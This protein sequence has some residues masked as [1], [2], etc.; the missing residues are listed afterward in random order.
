MAGDI[1]KVKDL[2]GLVEY[3]SAKLGWDIDFEDFDDIGDITY[4]FDASDIGLKEEAFAKISALRQLPPL[5]DGQRWGIFSVEFDSKRFEVTALRKILSGLIP[6]RRN[7]ADHAVWDQ[8]DLL[9]LCFWGEGNERTVGV[10]HFAEKESGLPQIRM[11]YCAP[12][13]EDFTQINVFERRLAQLEW[14]KDPSDTERWQN[15]WSTAFK[16]AYRQIITD[17][18]TLTIQLACEAQNIRNLILA[19]LE[20][21]AANGYVHTL[22]DRFKSTLIHDMTEQQFADM[23][24]QTVVYGLFSARC[25]DT[26]QEDFSAAEAVEC[27]PNTNPFLKHLMKECLGAQENSRLSFDELGIGDVVDLLRYTRTD[28][29]IQDFNRQTGGGREDPV[30]HFYEEFL[31]AYDKAQKVQ[32]GV[33]YTP[34]PVVNFI[35]RAVDE[36]L[37]NEFGIAD[38]LAST[39]TKKIHI[40]RDSRRKLDGFYRKVEDTADVP[41]VQVLDP[42]TGTGTFLRQVILQIYSNYKEM[43]KAGKETEDG[44]DAYVEEQLLPRINGFELMMAPYAVAHMKLAMVLRDTGYD[45]SSDSRLNVYLTNTLEKPGTSESQ[46]AFWDD[47]L[48]TESVEANGVKKNMGINV[49]IGNPPYLSASNSKSEFISGLMQDYKIEP[50]GQIKLQERKNWLD[51]DYVKFLRFSENIIEKSGAGVVGFINPHGWLENGGFR[52]M[53]W[54]LLTSFDEIYILNLHGN[55]KKQ[56]TCPDGSKDENVFDI[57]QGVCINLLVKTKTNPDR[58]KIAK[59]YYAD[60]YGLRDQKYSFLSTHTIANID[61]AEIHPDEP[62]FYLIPRDFSGIEAYRTGFAIN[63]VFIVSSQ[64]VMSGN[65]VCVMFESR[66]DAQETIE[67]AIHA[68]TMDKAVHVIC[69][70]KKLPKNWNPKDAINDL[71]AGY[72]LEE[73]QYRPFEKRYTA[74]SGRS[75]GWLW[76]PRTE[77]MAHLMGKHENIALVLTR[78]VQK[79]TEYAHVYISNRI[80][81]KG[82]LSSK[83]N[84]F[85][86]PLYLYHD[87]M[88]RTE[89]HPNLNLQ[90]I[91]VMT[92]SLGI[93]INEEKQTAD[94]NSFC[95]QD[96]FDYIYGY[97]FSPSYRKVFREFLMT[98]FPRIP[99]PRTL[100]FFWNVVDCGSKLRRLHL[101]GPTQKETI[102]FTGM[103]YLVETVNYSDSVIWINRTTY[104]NGISKEVWEFNVG[105]YQIIPRWLK[106]RKEIRLSEKDL[107]AFGEIVGVIKETVS[108]M[109]TLDVLTVEMN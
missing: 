53:R 82:L 21:E 33:F 32:R 27:I 10:A 109:Q 84:A 70:G 17:S 18:S 81:D 15:D 7:S 9:F 1:R 36:L 67:N 14:P 76:R 64:G 54:R 19:A 102:T 66:K 100:D 89:R 51:D 71:R 75:C 55:S 52:G 80:T 92:R 77:T 39:D 91:D 96:V 56:E 29:I 62:M 108:I 2:H 3:F 38:G 105:S 20:V 97:L 40:Q 46:M 94:R 42:S 11:I 69:D 4:D 43:V 5:V 25:M 61:W 85:V 68:E 106:E 30:I 83:D 49:I 22:Y 48:A 44:W 41:A 98:D 78:I 103:N 8:K 72:S 47:P 50:G 88:G 63:E 95:L 13:M 86:F 87:K 59:V 101:E 35:V 31:T 57:Q 79:G 74:F 28:A 107:N 23:Y 60:L 26:S 90:L 45:F 58:R 24:A 73:I 34:Q 12:A 65:D 6:K 16:T 104:I 93:P 37:K 99:Y